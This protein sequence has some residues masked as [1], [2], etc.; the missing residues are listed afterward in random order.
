[1]K[2][3]EVLL[4]RPSLRPKR[5]KKHTECGACPIGAREECVGVI[6]QKNSLPLACKTENIH[7]FLID[8]A[9]F[10]SQVARA[11][12]KKGSV[13]ALGDRFGSEGLSHPGRTGKHED[14][15][16]AFAMGVSSLGIYSEASIALRGT[17]THTFAAN[18]ISKLKVSVHVHG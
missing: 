11:D 4:G 16:F 2:V 5:R 8:A 9:G 18:E 10:A 14:E 1:M 7:D 12:N 6:E 13:E 15:A 3:G 17:D